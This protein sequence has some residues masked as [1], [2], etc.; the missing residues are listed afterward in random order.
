MPLPAG[1]TL[2]SPTQ[3]SGVNLPPGYTLDQPLHPAHQEALGLIDQLRNYADTALAPNTNGS[4]PI[5][6]TLLGAA[7][8]VSNL[9]LH[10]VKSL[11]ENGSAPGNY[12]GMAYTGYQPA[13]E[14]NAQ[15]PATAPLVQNA[16]A[17]VSAAKNNPAYT[18]GSIAGPLLA[19]AGAAKGV[20]AILPD[21]IVPGQN[22][23]PS[24]A[25]A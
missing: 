24:H 13:D 20:G 19:T 10:P 6:N 8:G 11:L 16:A 14:A 25:N 3:P 1:Y 21:D 12:P 2:N 5:E 17:A 15:N 9:V 22:Y 4:H 7:H 23:A 18:A